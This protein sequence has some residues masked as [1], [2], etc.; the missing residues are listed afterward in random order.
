MAQTA[1]AFDVDD[2]MD[3]DVIPTP[4]P[5]QSNSA[6][7]TP[8]MRLVGRT[9]ASESWWLNQP[10]EGFTQR[11]LAQVERMRDGS[12]ASAVLGIALE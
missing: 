12:A 9:K 8:R 1:L 6:L 11:A 4:K 5:K 3:D 10:A 7:F 2:D